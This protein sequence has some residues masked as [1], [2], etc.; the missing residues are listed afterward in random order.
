MTTVCE[1]A[2]AGERPVFIRPS[3]VRYREDEILRGYKLYFILARIRAQ[4]A[5]SAP[6]PRDRNPGR[7]EADLSGLALG[8]GGVKKV[9]IIKDLFS[10]VNLPMV[11]PVAAGCCL[12]DWKP[13]GRAGGA[14]VSRWS[15]EVLA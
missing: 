5:I 10:Q 9:R 1:C 2:G 12:S 11:L 7:Q 13:A 15:L 8:T 14:V 6:S 4:K 3:F